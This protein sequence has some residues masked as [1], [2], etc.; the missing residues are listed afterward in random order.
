MYTSIDI[1]KDLHSCSRGNHLDNN[2]RGVN[3]FIELSP[4]ALR[5]ALV[6]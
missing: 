5:L 2:V 4:D 6:K 3:H 1:R